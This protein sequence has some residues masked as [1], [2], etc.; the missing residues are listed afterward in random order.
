MRQAVAAFNPT[1]EAKLREE[2]MMAD[3]GKMRRELEKLGTTVR[4]LDIELD[5]LRARVTD[6]ENFGFQ[7][8]AAGTAVADATAKG[9]TIRKGGGYKKGKGGKGGKVSRYKKGKGG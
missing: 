8:V 1:K 2:R 5:A 4:R 6:L 7:V 9:V 3:I